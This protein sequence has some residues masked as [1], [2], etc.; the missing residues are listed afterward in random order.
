[1]D[2]GES[3][4]SG[5]ISYSG[6]VGIND[7]LQLLL[8]AELGVPGDPAA[9]ITVQSPLFPVSYTFEEIPTGTYWASAQF[10]IGGNNPSFP[11]GEEDPVGNYGPILLSPGG[12]VNTASFPVAT[13]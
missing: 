11:A 3:E 4:V 8:L 6:P 5:T 13:E 10:D 9:Q 2:I 1:M 12:S 7:V